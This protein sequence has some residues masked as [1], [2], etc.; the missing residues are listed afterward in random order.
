M[1]T[2]VIIFFAAIASLLFYSG[3]IMIAKG[4]TKLFGRQLSGTSARVF[5]A[6]I[7]LVGLIPL[8]I[9]IVYATAI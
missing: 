7:I 5:G 3:I 1:N 2:A 6:I 4:N 9:A 8:G